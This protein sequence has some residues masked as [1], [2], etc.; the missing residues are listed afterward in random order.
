[1]AFFCKLRFQIFQI[2]IFNL[3][4]MRIFW[5][6]IK[7]SLDSVRLFFFFF[8][9]SFFLKHSFF[10]SFWFGISFLDL[11]I[12]LYIDIAQSFLYHLQSV[13]SFNYIFFVLVI[14]LFAFIIYIYFAVLIFQL[15][16]YFYLFLF[17]IF[18]KFANYLFYRLLTFCLNLSLLGISIN[19]SLISC[20]SY[21]FKESPFSFASFFFSYFT[22]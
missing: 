14:F 4:Q 9:Y 3:L 5:V 13:F 1:M 2:T 17:F 21:S 16:L 8:L 11:I 15:Y 20:Y 19:W 7:K 12:H 10:H 22:L 6:I 18:L